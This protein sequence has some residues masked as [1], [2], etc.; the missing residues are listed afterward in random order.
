MINHIVIF[1]LKQGSIDE[2][3]RIILERARKE[4]TGIP[5]VRNLGAGSPMPTERK[6]VD[7]S[8]HAALTMQFDSDADLQ[9]YQVHPIHQKFLKECVEPFVERLV[10]YDFC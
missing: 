8:Y 3:K 4:L 6:V 10:V 1:W 5:G 7:T 9:K 2:G